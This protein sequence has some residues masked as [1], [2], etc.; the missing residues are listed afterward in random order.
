MSDDEIDK[1][2]VVDEFDFKTVDRTLILTIV[3]KQFT[4]I[5]ITIRKRKRQSVEIIAQWTVAKGVTAFEL[6][7]VMLAVE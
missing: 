3:L 4:S 1:R 7:T 5:S 2:P 6:A